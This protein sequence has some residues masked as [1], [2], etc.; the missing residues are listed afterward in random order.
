MRILTLIAFTCAFL[1]LSG[2]RY[3]GDAASGGVDPNSDFA[4][5]R[6][7]AFQMSAP[8]GVSGATAATIGFFS[9]GDLYPDVLVHTSSAGM[10]YY[11]NTEGEG[12]SAGVKVTA[13]F[14][15]HSASALYGTNTIATADVSTG[16]LRILKQANGAFT[17]TA[18]YELSGSPVASL[19]VAGNFIFAMTN[20]GVS[21]FTKFLP[22]DYDSAI[23]AA[24]EFSAISGRARSGDLNADAFPEIVVFGGPGSVQP[25]IYRGSATAVPALVGGT[26]I[27]R[28]A[29]S[30]VNDFAMAKFSSASKPDLIVLSDSGVEF[31]S[32]QSDAGSFSFVLNSGVSVT[33]TGSK[34]LAA[35]FFNQDGKV[36]LFVSRASDTARIYKQ[37]ASGT[38]FEDV[39]TQVFE[40]SALGS[41][42]TEIYT[43]DVNADGYVDILELYPNASV[44]VYINNRKSL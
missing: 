2:C 24:P 25:R 13:S 11:A 21:Y 38:S 15:N 23:T 30:D 1:S 6:S 22:S 14:Q 5:L 4:F 18:G 37:T 19:A 32:N 29:T 31:Y 28:V 43:A 40:P 26:P 44:R 35:D 7:S 33:A 42:P 20:P 10:V 16:T 3:D 9:P 36:D 27:A 34:I 12:F 8:S 39:T 41:G 17:Q